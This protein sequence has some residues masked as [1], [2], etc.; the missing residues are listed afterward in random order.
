MFDKVADPAALKDLLW[1]DVKFYRQ[2]WEVIYSVCDNDETFVPAGN[3]LG[4]D[5]VAGF[6][7]A[8]F[9]LTRHPVRVVTTSAK[10]DHLRV[11]WGEIG[12]FVNSSRIP[13]KV[14]DG[15]CLVVNHQDL[16]KVVGGVKCPISYAMSM[17][18]SPQSMAA[19]QG[20]HVAK[21]G[22]GVPRT[23]FVSDE[24]SSV[25]N[26]YYNMAKTWMNR[27]LVI[28]NTWPCENFFKH[29][30]KGRP[31]TDDKGGDLP[32]DTPGRFYRKVIKIRAE[33]SPN[34]RV[35]LAQIEAGQEPTG[36]MV[37]DGV[38]DWDEY[39]KNRL[40]WDAVQQCVSLDAEFYEGADARLY[41]PEWVAASAAYALTLAGVRRVALAAGVD[42]AEGGDS[43]AM[44]AV[45]ERGVIELVSLKTPDTNVIPGLVLAFMHKHGLR[46]GQV[47]FDRGGGGKQH[48]DR[49]RAM[50]HKVRTVGF[51]EGV[52]EDVKPW[53]LQLKEKLETKE[54]RYVYT[55]RRCQMYGTLR[56][57]IEP[58]AKGLSTFG[59][60]ARYPAFAAQMAPIPLMYDSEGRLKVPPKSKRS[61]MDTGPTLVGL[62]GHSPDELDAL[63]LACHVMA[64]TEVKA[65][66]GAM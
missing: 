31:G 2:Q 23:L 45:D 17:V 39:K 55:N 40:T 48:A 65:M 21:T 33:D 49:L 25:P 59:V 24:S 51:G 12:R 1:P 38:K 66:A 41:P 42:T 36:E 44:V 61:P 29:A 4:K 9:V 18:A 5:F 52:T 26:E 58:D 60:P 22:D 32:S 15:G 13:L 57:L 56:N 3:M 11:L 64:Y 16:R 10:D 6:I 50:G 43:T 63:V 37:V 30:I 7:V 47:G 14:E 19:M 27:S 35:A 20:H 53:K 54:T 28:G 8:Y 46:G 34:V 62:I